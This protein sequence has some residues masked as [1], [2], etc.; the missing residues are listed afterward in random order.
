MWPIPTLERELC[1]ISLSA[2]SIACS[3]V[4]KINKGRAPLIVHAYQRHNF[5][6]AEFERNVLFNPTI[7]KRQIV[8][9][10]NEYNKKNAFVAMSLDGVTVI[11]R[12]V[13]LSSSTAHAADFSFAQSSNNVWGYRYLYP[14]DHGQFIFYVYSVPRSLIMQCQLIASAVPCNLITITTK[15][16]ALFHTYKYVFGEAF[17]TS[18]FAIDMIRHDNKLDNLIAVDVLKRIIQAHQVD[19]AQERSYIAQVCGLFCDERIIE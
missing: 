7:I 18:Q 10:L 15:T 14:N 8:S 3:W 9:F 17:R 4:Q 11:E 16:I 1:T 13:A 19:I 5:D 2:D 6:A 12:F